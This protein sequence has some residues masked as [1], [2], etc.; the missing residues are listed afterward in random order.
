MVVKKLFILLFTISTFSQEIPIIDFSLGDYPINKKFKIGF[1]SQGYYTMDLDS[2]SDFSIIKF[3]EKNIPE[4]EFITYY[5][6]GEVK[7]RIFYDFYSNDSTSING[8]YTTYHKNGNISEALFFLK[9]K[10]Y[11]PYNKYYESGK[12][13]INGNYINGLRN[14]K[15]TFFYES[16]IIEYIENIVND[17]R[18]GQYEAYYESGAI[19][20]TGNYING[21]ADGE[22]TFYYESGALQHTGIYVNGLSEGKFTFYYDS[23][24]KDLVGTVQEIRNYKQDLVDGQQIIYN[25]LGELSEIRNYK[26]GLQDG[27]S[28]AYYFKDEDDLSLTDQKAQGG[29]QKL[30]FLYKNDTIVSE[31]QFDLSKKVIY[32]NKNYLLNNDAIFYY[33]SGSVRSITPHSNGKKNGIEKIFYENTEKIWQTLTWLDGAKNGKFISYYQSGNTQSIGNYVSD[34]LE[35]EVTTYYDSSSKDQDRNIKSTYNYV[36]DLLDGK[37]TNYYESGSTE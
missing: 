25:E 13:K 36:N 12:P 34:V 17:L 26:N 33:P 27:E 16:G 30:I 7:S 6:G 22:W 3:K 19:Q 14:G 4:G 24:S 2:I 32:E 9:N 37:Y 1:N 5:S 35:G 15:W 31:K 10:W 23:G 20:L 18:E 28:I 29:E 8:P 21:L 11:G